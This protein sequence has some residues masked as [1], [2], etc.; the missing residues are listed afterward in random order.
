MPKLLFC[1]MHVMSLKTILLKLQPLS[2]GVNEFRLNILFN[3][4]VT[5][6]PRKWCCH[7]WVWLPAYQID[8]L[9][10]SALKLQ[11]NEKANIEYRCYEGRPFLHANVV[12]Q[13]SILYITCYIWV[14]A[15][16]H[17][18][19]TFHGSIFLINGHSCHKTT[20]QVASLRR[21]RV[22]SLL[23]KSFPKH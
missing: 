10:N 14:Y 9:A 19:I 23:D 5:E 6:F 1:I 8:F 12:A 16:N 22:I 11:I 3:A 17:M 21:S 15:D 2:P 4:E 7:N 18:M 13:E 20:R